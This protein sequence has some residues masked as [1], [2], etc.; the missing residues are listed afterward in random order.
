VSWWKAIGHRIGH[1]GR[2]SRFDAEMD[3]ELRFHLDS[4]IDDLERAGLSHEDAVAQARRRLGSRLRTIEDARQAWQFRWIERLASNLRYALRQCRKHPGFAALVILTL[5]LGIGANSAVFAAVDAVFLRSLPFPEADRL[6]DVYQRHPKTPLTQTAPARLEDWNR[7]NHTFQAMTGFYAEDVSET[8]GDLPEKLTQV[9]VAPRFLDVWGVTPALGRDLSPDELREGGAPAVLISDGFWRRRF[10]ADPGAVGR[11][12]RI[13]GLSPTIVGVMPATFQFP[14]R[15][16]DVWWPVPFG[17]MWAQPR[18]R[19]ATVYFTVGR[20]KRGVSIAQARAD[21]ATVQSQLVKTYPKTDADLSADVQPLDAEMVRPVR[22]S[23]WLMFGSASVLLLIACV[24]V[25][26]LLLLRSLQRQ[27]EMTIRASLGGSRRE[28]VWQ[29]LTE[30]G[31]L[32]V[33]GAGLG[34]AIAAAAT[35]IFRVFAGSLPRMDEIRIDW[36]IALYALAAAVTVTFVCGLCP[37]LRATAGNLNLRLLRTAPRHGAGR[38]RLQWML[39]GIQIS[40]AVTL[41]VAAGLLVRT[42]QE[43]GRVSP[44]FEVRSILTF[45]VSASYAETTDYR[46]MT[47]RIDRTLDTLRAIPGVE[48]ATTVEALPGIPGRAQREVT[49]VEGRSEDQPKLFADNRYVAGSYFETLKIPLLS[50]E[51]CRQTAAVQAMSAPRPPMVQAALVNRSFA[52]VY[53][54]GSS[55]IGHRLVDAGGGPGALIS[56]IVADTREQGLNAPPGPTV[57]WCFSAPGPTP[58]F[59]IR[60]I[61]DPAAIA[62]TVRRK[63]KELEPARAVF[64]LTP[65]EE[66]LDE[67]YRENGLR[68]VIVAGFSISAVLLALIGLY[69]TLGYLVDTRRREVGVRLALGALRQHIIGR[70][71]AQGLVVATIA[72]AIGLGVSVLFGRLLSGMLYGVSTADPTTLGFVAVIILGGAGIASLLPS[73]RG[74][75][76][77]PV[78]VLRDE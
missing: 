34:L 67:A 24:N 12:L 28:V 36:R 10:A 71:F 51:W 57:Y 76:V 14:I 30:T 40:M 18:M 19:A 16:A 65:L 13:G 45:H 75:R 39:A 20:L 9:W 55:P 74:A 3:I 43:I 56:G 78:Q 25:A 32:A 23:V 60:T 44:G 8:S 35:R 53:F 1:F 6:V 31:V 38:H 2:R 17:G 15:D 73:V 54:S 64:G 33:L 50:G 49:L 4:Q 37:A 41:L 62:G 42:L 47:E 48:A 5:G 63:M 27:H 66:H 69:G 29:L 22:G 26:G 58:F 11:Q 46:R 59:L 70:F 77:E 7:M 61:G 52:N 72:C 68:A 21:L